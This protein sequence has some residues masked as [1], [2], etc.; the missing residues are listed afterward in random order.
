MNLTRYSF[1]WLTVVIALVGVVLVVFLLLVNMTVSNGTI[2]GLVFYANILSFS[3]L[4]D[5]KTCSIHP[6]LRVFLSWINLDF[7]I[8]VCFYSGMDVYQKT[9]LQFVFSFYIW[10]LVGVII[11]FCHYFSTIMKLMG[12]RNI[13]VLATLFMLSYAK[14]LKTIV[15]ALSFTDILVASANNVSDPLIPQRVWVYSGHMK[16][17]N[18]KHLALV[19]V[20][21]LFLMAPFLPYTVCYYSDNACNTCLKGGDYDV[22]LVQPSPPSWMPIMPPTPNTIATGLD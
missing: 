1:I 4:L 17:L 3:G 18:N 8:E 15:T 9:W 22:S 10:F 5:Y 11:L 7:S 13:E 12:M 20:S 14:L 19:I 16:Y 21:L 6:I 2:N